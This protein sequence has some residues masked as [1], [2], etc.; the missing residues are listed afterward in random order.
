MKRTVPK[1]DG[2]L[3]GWGLL[4]LSSQAD[5]LEMAG[6][7]LHLHLNGSL[8]TLGY[9]ICRIG[10][11][12]RIPIVFFIIS[13]KK[14]PWGEENFRSD[15][16]PPGAPDAAGVPTIPTSNVS[17]LPPPLETEIKDETGDVVGGC[18]WRLER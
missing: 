14:K 17:V 15:F 9:M 10:R 7:L 11:I 3:A 16:F 6:R 13:S 18:W 1:K 5:S 4:T 2:Q 8:R 12:C